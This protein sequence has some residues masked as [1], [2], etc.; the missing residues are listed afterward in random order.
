M[1]PATELP[2]PHGEGPPVP[3]M[4][5]ADLDA[6]ALGRL[7]ADLAAAAEVLSV[8]GK[9]GQRGYASDDQITPS[10]A[11]EQ[12]AAGVLAGVQVRYRY[13]GHEWTDTVLRTAGGFRLVRCRVV[14]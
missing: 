8:R 4:W 11:H 7:F 9:G 2:R 6:D 12:L 5:Q 10:T 14:G 1:P 13:D 3:P